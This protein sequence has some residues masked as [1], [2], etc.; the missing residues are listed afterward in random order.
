MAKFIDKMPPK[1]TG[2]LKKDVAAIFEYQTY[3]REQINFILNLLYKQNRE[4]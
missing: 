3:L 2:D 4:G 1:P